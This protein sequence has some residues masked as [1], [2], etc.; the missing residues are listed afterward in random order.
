M[1]ADPLG[2]RLRFLITPGQA[3]DLTAAPALLK[4]QEAGAVRADKA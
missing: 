1:L 4:G 2:R 3:S